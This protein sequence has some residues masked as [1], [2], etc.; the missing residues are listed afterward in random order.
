MEETR[1]SCQRFV[2]NRAVSL[3]TLHNID[4]LTDGLRKSRGISDDYGGLNACAQEINN[5]FGTNVSGWSGNDNFHRK[6]RIP[7]TPRTIYDQS[8]QF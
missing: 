1:S 8:S 7:Q 6:G 3:V 2:Q 5:D 4:L